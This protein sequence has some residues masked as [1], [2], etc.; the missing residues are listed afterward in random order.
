MGIISN[1]RMQKIGHL[2]KLSIYGEFLIRALEVN[3]P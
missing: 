2:K 1:G 3:S